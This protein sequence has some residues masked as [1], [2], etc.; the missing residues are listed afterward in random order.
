MGATTYSKKRE[1]K[2]VCVNFESLNLN[3]YHKKIEA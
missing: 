2:I 3:L 1:K